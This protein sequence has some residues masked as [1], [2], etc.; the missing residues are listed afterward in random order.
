MVGDNPAL[1]YS[2]N[3]YLVLKKHKEK[4]LIGRKN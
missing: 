4:V 1:K 2:F 3:E